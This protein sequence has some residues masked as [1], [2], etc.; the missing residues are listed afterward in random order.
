MD[1]K[2][3]NILK[4]KAKAYFASL[5]SSEVKKEFLKDSLLNQNKKLSKG[6]NVN[7]GLEL[8]PSTFV[9][10]F[11]MCGGEGACLLTCLVF[12][13]VDNLLKSKSLE[14]SNTLKKRIRRTFMFLNEREF[15]VEKLKSEVTMLG[16]TYKNVAVRLNVVSD[17]DWSK[18][19][20]LSSFAENVKF[21]DY[22]KKSSNITNNKRISFTYSASEKDSD[23]DLQTMLSKGYNVAMV[24]K[25]VPQTWNGFEVIDGDKNDDRYNDKKGV[26]VG[27]KQKTTIGGQTSSKFIK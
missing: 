9:S 3:Y 24:F 11:N 2:T 5:D 27:L 23:E 18:V 20:D 16:H 26:V 14:L 22:T 7:F 13:G 21:Y 25:K 19:L 12:S 4:E 15:F 1:A 10:N 17:L 6:D 8:T